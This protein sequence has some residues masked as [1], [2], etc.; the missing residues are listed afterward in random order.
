LNLFKAIQW[1]KLTPAQ[2]LVFGYFSIII[3][4]TILFMLP[5]ATV[6]S[7]GLNLIDAL[8]TATS[9]TCVTG[10]VVVNTSRTFTVFGQLVIMILIQIGGLGLM[11]M[12]TMVAFFIGKK[13]S[14]KERLLIQEDMN[15]FKISG[16]VRLVRYVLGLTFII[17]ALGAVFLFLG[18]I[19]ERS[20]FQSIYFSIFHSISAFNNAGFDL[21]EN[22]LTNFKGNCIVNIVVILLIIIGGL[23]FGVIVEVFDKRNIKNTSLQTKIVLTM[24]AILI[25]TGFLS[26]FLLEFNNNSTIGNLSFGKKIMSSIF[27]SVTSRTAGFNTIPTAGL[28]GSTLFII[29]VLMFI[30]A[31]PGSTGGGI[32]TTTFGVLLIT[33]WSMIIG[34]RDIEIYNRQLE[35][36]VIFKALSIIMLSFGLLIF[37]T[38]LLTVVEDIDF[39]KVLFESVSAFGTVG[40]S[41]GI[42]PSLS[43]FGRLLITM[44]MFTGRVGPLTLALAF[45]ERKRNGMYHYPKEKIMVG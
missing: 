32:K 5:I 39:L 13:I 21:F 9:A 38:V 2:I 40:L 4:G 22:S 16:L 34:K 37:V 11:T 31:S 33:M 43:E 1:D 23:G 25:I 41:T 15:Q 14:L 8:F 45:A 28:R 18:L 7:K 3:L 24:T 36:E 30:G 19:K 17:E 44:T 20:F 27:L 35:K 42:T 12:S 6:N 29:I 10:L 26:V